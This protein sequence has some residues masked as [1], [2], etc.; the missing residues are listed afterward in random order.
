L[1]P[2]TRHMIDARRLA[3]MKP[4]AVLVNTARGPVVDEAALVVALRE[5]RI[6]AAGFDVYE[7]EPALAPGLAELEN[8]V[9]LPHLGSATI[10]TRDEMGRLC[11]QAVVD[12]LQGREP[13][14]AVV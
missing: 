4:S 9:L 6:A 1:T 13:K 7:N 14:H 5:R 8:A 2:Q 10:E 3:L 11:A 12:V